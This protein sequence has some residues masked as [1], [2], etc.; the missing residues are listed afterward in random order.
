MNE[1]QEYNLLEKEALEKSRG[2]NINNLFGSD[3]VGRF[4]CVKCGHFPVSSKIVEFYHKQ[5]ELVECYE[6]QEIN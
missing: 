2:T 4:K 5:V 6:C 3:L 1:Y